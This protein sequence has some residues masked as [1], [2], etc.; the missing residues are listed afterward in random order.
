MFK[1]HDTP[2]AGHAGQ[3]HAH[4]LLAQTYWWPTMLS[5][6][7]SYVEGCEACQRN[8]I[9]RQRKHAPLHPHATPELPWEEA[10]ADVIGPLPES[11]GYNAILVVTDKLY[12]QCHMIPTTVEL[13]AEG[14]AKLYRDYIWKLHGIPKKMIS[15]RGPQFAAKFMEEL[16]KILGV[17]R[18]LSTAYHPQTDGQAERSHQETEAFLRA[19]VN[20]LQDDW[21]EWLAIMEFQY[22]DKVHSATHETDED[23]LLYRVDTDITSR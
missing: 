17:S 11:N 6:T 5:D 21:S 2:V 9:N 12:K 14:A 18:N 13:T 1:H 20:Q 4:E 15:D 23:W 10:A 3:W 8:K 22:N 19:F 16:F 7:K